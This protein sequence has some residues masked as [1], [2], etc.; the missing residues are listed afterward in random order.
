MWTETGG[1]TGV[2][3]EGKTIELLVADLAALGVTV[4]V[5]VRLNAISR[6]KGFSKRA[7]ADAVEAAGIS[8]QHRPEL[9]NARD[10][11]AGFSEEWRTDLGRAA[12]AKYADGLTMPDAAAAIDELADLAS[13]VKVALLCFEASELHCHRREALTAIRNRMNEFVSA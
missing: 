13:T 5:D 9:G 7:L 10:N 12:R 3:Y 6:K 1:L 11:R 8:Y 2:G 4:L